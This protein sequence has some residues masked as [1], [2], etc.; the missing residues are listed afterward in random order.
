MKPGRPHFFGESVYRQIS[1]D[2]GGRGSLDLNAKKSEVEGF[3][4]TAYSAYKES[5]YSQSYAL[6]NEGVHKYGKNVYLPKFE[7]IRS[8]SIG[9]LKGI[10]TLEHN[11]KL[12]VAKYPDADVTPAA[13][14]Q[15]TQA[16]NIGF[17]IPIAHALD[18]ARQIIAGN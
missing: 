16:S 2:L 1:E 7:F 4:A 15:G 17:V 11:S 10:D 18:L 3:Y 9:R 8:M 6:A 13:S 5:N 14:G 12:L